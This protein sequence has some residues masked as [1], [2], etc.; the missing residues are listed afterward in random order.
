MNYTEIKDTALLYTDRVNDVE[1]LAIY[2]N[3]LRVVESRVNS[4]LLTK[5][6]TSVSTTPIIS[7]VTYYALPDDFLS[8]RS[9]CIV[10]DVGAKT[11]LNYL[12]PEHMDINTTN[13]LDYDAY[14]IVGTNLQIS[15]GM[16]KTDGTAFIQIIYYKRVPPINETTQLTNWL[17]IRYPECY[18]FGLLVEFNSY[19][20]DAGAVELW[21]ARFK[22][23]LESI[24]LQE[25]K[26]IWSGNPLAMRVS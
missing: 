15:S 16:A 8:E 24:D 11:P 4:K 9:I 6:M 19:V 10:N 12:V 1:L 13:N 20:K 21:E 25:V 23:S 3:M 14:T 17:S 5:Q 7:G 22:E 18:I 26:S 2:D